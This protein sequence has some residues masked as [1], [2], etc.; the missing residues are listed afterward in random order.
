MTVLADAAKLSEVEGATYT[1][2]WDVDNATTQAYDVVDRPMFV[3]IDADMTIRLRA[4]NGAGM[5]E[6]EELITELLGL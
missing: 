2:L 3:V 1:V 4:S 5:H 6:A